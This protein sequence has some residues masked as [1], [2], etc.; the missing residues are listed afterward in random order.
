MGSL[1]SSSHLSKVDAI[2]QQTKESDSGLACLTGGAP[3]R[4]ASSANGY[5]FSRGSFYPPTIFA[6]EREGDPRV[7]EGKMRSSPIW[8]QEVFGPVVVC[9]PFEDEAHAIELAN[10]CDYSLGASIWTRDVSR[11]TQ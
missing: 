11:T 3:L 2:V 7:S 5:D 10:D 8:K 9:C 1:I 6:L 4:G